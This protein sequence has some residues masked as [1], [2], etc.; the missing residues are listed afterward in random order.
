MCGI[1]QLQGLRL[2]VSQTTFIF[3]V[4]LDPHNLYLA[5]KQPSREPNLEPA[6]DSSRQISSLLHCSCSQAV[7]YLIRCDPNTLHVCCE[8]GAKQLLCYCYVGA[9]QLLRLWL[10]GRH[11]IPIFIVVCGLKQLQGLRL[12]VGQTTLFFM[13]T[14]EPNNLSLE[15]KQPSR[16]P[17][18]EPSCASS[19]TK[20]FIVTWCM[21]P[22]SFCFEYYV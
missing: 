19:R 4:V 6:C 1:K 10:C 18:V 2:F 13:V 5:A 12:F 20:L 21:E 11:T 14:W 9:K 16:E 8:L 3:M 17:Q 15:A 22:S 7:F